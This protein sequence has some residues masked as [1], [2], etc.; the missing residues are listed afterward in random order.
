MRELYELKFKAT[1]KHTNRR[2]RIKAIV[3]LEKSGPVRMKSGAIYNVLRDYDLSGMYNFMDISL[4]KL[5]REC[6]IVEME[7]DL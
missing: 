7:L 3:S 4:V 5:E 1:H 2:V 6:Y